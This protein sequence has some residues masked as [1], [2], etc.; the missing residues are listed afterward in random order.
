MGV[1]LLSETGSSRLISSGVVMRHWAPKNVFLFLFLAMLDRG[2]VHCS[3]FWLGFCSSSGIL[4]VGS[5]P[6]DDRYQSSFYVCNNIHMSCSMV[7][8]IGYLFVS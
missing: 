2:Y 4:E 1:S 3:L 5:G 8:E 6:I 7:F